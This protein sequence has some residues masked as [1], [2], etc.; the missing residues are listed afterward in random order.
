MKKTLANQRFL[1]KIVTAFIKYLPSGL[2][3]WQIVMLCLNFAGISMP[4]LGFLGGSS[5]IF[6]I[7]L[8]LLSYLFQYCYLYR[9]PLSYNLVINTIVLLRTCGLIPIDLLLLYRVFMIITGI[10]IAIFV[11]FMYKNRNNPKVGGI[12]SFCEKYCDC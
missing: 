9:M 10:F 5:L 12:K 6:L 3:L 1:Y 4:I 7:L 8:Y 2:A 11:F